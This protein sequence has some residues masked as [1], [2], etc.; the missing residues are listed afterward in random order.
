MST[1]AAWRVGRFES[2]WAHQRKAA[3]SSL[4]SNISTLALG[5]YPYRCPVYILSVVSR[6]GE[7]GAYFSPPRSGSEA[8]VTT[9]CLH[10]HMVILRGE[11]S[12]QGKNQRHERTQ[13][14][15]DSRSVWNAKAKKRIPI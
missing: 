13:R 8:S 4:L 11:D 10:N 9:V 6:E 7:G 12:I 15:P 3:V 2:C 1:E 14:L 5:P